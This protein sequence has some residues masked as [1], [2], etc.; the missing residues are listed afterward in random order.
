MKA[1][2]LAA[3]K[4]ERMRPLTLTTP[5]PL[6]PVAGK[7]LIQWHIEALAEA[8]MPRLVIN[9]AWLGEQL[10][11]RFGNGDDFG[12]QISWSAEGEPL[13]TAGGILRALPLLGEAPFLL[14]NGDIFTDFDFSGMRCDRDSLAHLVLVDNP[15]H[16][17]QG[18]FVL[19]DGQIRNPQPG[20]AALTYS[21]IAVLHPALFDG[22]KPGAA[23][24]A[25]LLRRAAD[26]GRVTGQHF[27]GVWIDVGTPERLAEADRQAQAR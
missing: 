19:V 21:G 9:H 25:L 24:L 6:L 2:I 8:G 1:M 22:L 23:A 5:K 7:P 15:A 11:R 12:V 17:D 16:K 4:G 26:Q 14:V 20:E 3:G 27:S 18:D 10:E 13:E